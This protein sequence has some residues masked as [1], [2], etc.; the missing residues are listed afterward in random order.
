METILRVSFPHEFKS[1]G[2]DMAFFSEM[3]AI[4][5]KSPK[6]AVVTIEYQGTDVHATAHDTPEAVYQ[7]YMASKM[8]P[9]RR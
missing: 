3:I 4:A 1:S 6:G 5:E 2:L 9:S 7:H 8:R